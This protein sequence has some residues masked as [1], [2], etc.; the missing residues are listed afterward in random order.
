MAAHFFR[1]TGNWDNVN[2]WS[3]TDGGGAGSTYPVAGDDVTIKT[4]GA[5]KTLTVNV[6]SACAT[7]T[8]SS[9]STATLAGSNALTVSG[10]AV[11]LSTMTV[12]YTG[13]LSVG[14]DFNSGTKTFTE[15][16]IVGATCA[17]VNSSSF[18]TLKFINP[19]A[20]QV[21]TIT[22]GKTL[23][24]SGTF[25]ATGQT[26]V[27]R[28]AITSDTT[29]HATINAGTVAVTKAT[30][31]YITG[32]GA[33]SWDLHASDV[34]QAVTS[35]CTGITFGLYWV[36]DA[37][38]TSNIAKW[39]SVSGATANAIIVPDS[40]TSAY[41]DANSFTL[42][43]QTVTVNASL[44]CLN[45]DWTNAGANNPDFAVQNSITIVNNQTYIAA[46]TITP[47]SGKYII[48]S[49]ACTLL[50]NTCV[51]GNLETSGAS[52]ALTL[53]DALNM[54]SNL[55]Y[56]KQGTFSTSA[57][58]F[59]VTCGNI[60]DSASANTKTVTLGNSTVSCTKWSF[61]GTGA[62]TLTANTATIN[63]SGTIFDGDSN[64]NYYIV[65]LTGTS[66]ITITG[67]NTFAQLNFICTTG[68]QTIM[69][70]AGS[71]QTCTTCNAHG[72][73]VDYPL[74]I[75]SSVAGTPATITAT[76]WTGSQN[77]GIKDVTATNAV[78]LS[79]IHSLN[80][81]GNT[82]IT[83]TTKMIQRLLIAVALYKV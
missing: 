25:T 75:I 81:G 71:T 26:T 16:D 11:F 56:I 3:D 30:L 67:N 57:S 5:T 48:V 68:K 44:S 10:N 52:A 15:V 33:G 65:N 36:G 17:I 76:N 74:R 42:D 1:A 29:S 13:I 27:N 49:G 50:T 83:F 82:N 21:V 64:A 12:T 9:A 18:T 23:T 19:S 39:S 60:S 62:L 35:S 61:T 38:N 73:S 20:A 4:T 80:F 54:G 78:N 59:S 14:G 37:G 34:L 63:M 47:T 46:M 6:D 7:I 55:L 22:H 8:C 66:A 77:V 72:Y 28:C 24:V 41:F 31:S 45:M 58:N 51:I 69:L 43:T 40:T 70:T 79:G 53:G 2:T 32:T